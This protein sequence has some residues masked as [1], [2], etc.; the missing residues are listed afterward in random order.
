MKNSRVINLDVLKYLKAKFSTVFSAEQSY[1]DGLADLRL[2]DWSQNAQVL[3]K[4]SPDFRCAETA[5]HV[6]SENHL[7]ELSFST[8]L[9]RPIVSPVI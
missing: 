1:H 6:Q 7:E 8:G 5:V 3:I 4:L 2:N 9:P